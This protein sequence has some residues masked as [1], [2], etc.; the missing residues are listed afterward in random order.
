M[1]VLN[2][3]LAIP[4]SS[5]SVVVFGFLVVVVV[6]VVIDV[7]VG[8][9]VVATVVVVVVVVFPDFSVDVVISGFSVGGKKGLE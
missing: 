5:F 8:G 9:A 6:A 7:V 4:E 1:N 2:L 3:F